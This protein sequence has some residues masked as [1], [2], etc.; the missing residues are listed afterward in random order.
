[1]TGAARIEEAATRAARVRP[2]DNYAGFDRGARVLAL[3]LVGA[4]GLAVLASLAACGASEAAPERRVPITLDPIGDTLCA[5][6]GHAKVGTEITEPTVR[7]Y[8]RGAGGDAA[9][10]SMIYRGETDEQRSLASGPARRQLGLKLRAKDGCN[11][12]YVMWRLDP[13]PKIEVSVKLN[14]GAKAHE[15]CGA[16]GYTKIKPTKSER[17]PVLAVG[18]R[19]Q[20][21]AAISG[22]DLTAWIDDKVVWRGRLPSAARTLEG[23]AGLRS[24]NLA[25]DLV[26]F[27]APAGDGTEP[28]ACKVEKSAD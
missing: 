24:D 18:D 20:L 12:V 6:H 4:I 27:K 21:R 9:E 19:H 17:V 3:A 8:A 13:K 15:Q 1:M 14:P 25:F 10:L 22:D 26:S 5:T 7:A 2:A 28:P 23:P 16:D 11:V